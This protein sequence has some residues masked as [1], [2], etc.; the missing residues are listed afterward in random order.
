MTDPTPTAQKLIEQAR[1]GH[2]P[3]AADEARVRAALHTRVLANPLLLSAKGSH[4]LAGA[5][6][7]G[8][9]KLVLA[10]G[11]G[12][13]AVV[14]ALVVSQGL[15][16][17]ESAQSAR[18]A[19]TPASL[20]ASA[21]RVG[22]APATAATAA[23][24]RDAVSTPNLD[25]PASSS[26]APLASQKRVLSPPTPAVSV[27]AGLSTRD[28]QLEISGLSRAQQ[29]LH[30]GSPG[31]ALSALDQLSEQVPRGALME[32]RDATRALAQC[33]LARSNNAANAFIAR[34][35]KSVHAASVR[36]ACD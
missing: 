30:S 33:A 14:G 4:A 34:Y 29:L 12:G 17:R 8:W 20:A 24:A 13:A 21:A 18:Q 11:L 36:A 31:Q 1:A 3:N 6:K 7:L 28:M 23:T 19:S 32:E 9:G 27:S 35:P 16:S 22:P 15:G 2:D 25:A 10:L 26:A 5:G